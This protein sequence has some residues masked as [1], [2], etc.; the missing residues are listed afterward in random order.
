M[1]SSIIT[2]ACTQTPDLIV[3]GQVNADQ[4][5]AL[6]IQL[7]AADALIVQASRPDDASVFLPLLYR[8]P[9]LKII[10]IDG[11]ARSGFVHELG[12]RSLHLPELSAELIQ[13]VLR[14]PLA[15][16]VETHR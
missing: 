1:L 16:V 5:L 3:T 6:Q 7:T 8:H 15:P 4:D 13:S 9:V 11:A 10:A 14:A 2:A 12:P